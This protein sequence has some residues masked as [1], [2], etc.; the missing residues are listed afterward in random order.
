MFGRLRPKDGIAALREC[1]SDWAETMPNREGNKIV[2]E[3]IVLD[4]VQE[5]KEVR[6][7]G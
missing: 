5:K 7:H 6:R 3:L 2:D 1:R 4:R